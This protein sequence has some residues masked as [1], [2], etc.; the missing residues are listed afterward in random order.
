MDT[1]NKEADFLFKNEDVECRI[2]FFKLDELNQSTKSRQKN[3][4]DEFYK[5]YFC[6]YPGDYG[7]ENQTKFCWY[8]GSCSDITARNDVI[9]KDCYCSVKLKNDVP[10]VRFNEMLYFFKNNTDKMY[11]ENKIKK[12]IENGYDDLCYDDKLEDY[13]RGCDF[14]NIYYDWIGIDEF[15]FLFRDEE[16]SIQDAFNWIKN[17]VFGFTNDYILVYMKS[18]LDF[19]EWA[20]NNKKLCRMYYVLHELYKNNKKE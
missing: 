11:W 19:V 20:K 18:G 9:N 6:T 3:K 1:Y 2:D 10:Y 7:F 17:V 8:T 13:D 4:E 16:E 15:I 12:M 14:F 5:M